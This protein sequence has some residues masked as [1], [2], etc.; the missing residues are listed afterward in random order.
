[1]KALPLKLSDF[2][3]VLL[4][5]VVLAGCNQN[6]HDVQSDKTKP[7]IS[8]T[9]PSLVM[10][11]V[12]DNVNA[13][14]FTIANS[15][16]VK[17]TDNSGSVIL[18]IADVVGLNKTQVQ[19][20]VDGTLTANNIL[21]TA[22]VGRGYV[23]IRATDS[24]GNYTDSKVY[25]D[26]SP[27]IASTQANV[28]VGQSLTLHFPVMANSQQAIVSLPT[29]ITGISSVANLVGNELVATFNTNNSAV[30]GELKPKFSIKTTTGDV[31]SF[32]LTI[33]LQDAVPV[34]STPPSK[35]SEDLP[36]I[37]AAGA[38][39]ATGIITLSEAVS[40]V[41]NVEFVDAATGLTLTDGG[42]VSA[43]INEVNAKIINFEYSIP[44]LGSSGWSRHKIVFTAVDNAGNSALIESDIYGVN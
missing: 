20:A 16:R 2:C 4:S 42:K 9:N 27:A 13:V 12:L 26:I 1:M 18:S 5:V 39:N 36:W 8:I 33:N 22:A 11:V 30:A 19:L 44:A 32:I 3:T 37:D 35:V 21:S 23:V 6:D 34:D 15:G 17:A 14:S 31:Y 29:N 38:T 25:F 28:T 41:S 43:K 7:T 24:S 10:G 40:S